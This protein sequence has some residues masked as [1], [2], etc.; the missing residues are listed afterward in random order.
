MELGPYELLDSLAMNQNLSSLEIGL[1]LGMNMHQESG[2]Y[3]PTYGANKTEDF[4]QPLVDTV[5]SLKLFNRLRSLKQGVELQNPTYLRR[6]RWP[7]K[8]GHMLRFEAWGETLAEIY[9]CSVREADGEPWCEQLSG[10]FSPPEKVMRVM[11]ATEFDLD[12]DGN[13]GEEAIAEL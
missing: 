7:R 13:S 10:D 4:R 2:Y 9:E 1:E 6:R 11:S 3:S 5:L 8:Y 12:G